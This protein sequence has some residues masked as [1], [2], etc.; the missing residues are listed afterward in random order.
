MLTRRDNFSPHHKFDSLLDF[1]SSFPPLEG[2][3]TIR[4][5]QGELD[6]K[7]VN[8]GSDTTLVLFHA[9]I[10]RRKVKHYPLFSGQRITRYLNANL[11]FV[12]DPSL[13]LGLDLGWF[14]GNRTQWL[15][16]DLPSILR[17]VSYSFGWDQKMIFFGASGG[18]FASLYYSWHFPG[19]T[20]ITVNPQTNIAEYTSSPVEAYANVAW[21][22]PDIE[23]SPI[24]FDL[25]S[26]Y[27]HGF[28]NRVIFLQNTF[29]GLHRDRHL[30]PWLRATPEPDNNMWLLMGRW[31]RGHTP[32]DSALLKQVLE[33]S[34]SPS[35]SSLEEL[36]FEQA[37]PRNRPKTWYQALKQAGSAS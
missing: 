3:S 27:S 5:G 37:P 21:D 11:I 30:A 22:V 36:G 23:S 31:G 18:G 24:T 8:R 20:A 6:I 1:Y 34:I 19:S 35:T 16:A 2:V 4:Y 9:A 33:A 25:R 7:V 13:A 26:L 10:Y 14:A 29:D 15:Q 28:P 32:P 17:H 12:S